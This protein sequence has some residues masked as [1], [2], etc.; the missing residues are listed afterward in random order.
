LGDSEPRGP[1]FLFLVDRF[2]PRPGGYARSLAA[3]LAHFP[4]ESAVV[5]TPRRSGAAV[6]DRA[7][8]CPVRRARTLVGPRGFGLRLWG[9]QVR[10]LVGRREPSLVVA[11]GLGP[12]ATFALSLRE[13]R[14]L[15]F[16][17]RVG[18]AEL[19][20]MRAAIQ[21]G[22]EAGQRAR[23][24]VDEAAA[25]LVP[26]RTAWLEAYKLHTRPHDIL[27]IAPGVDLERF[28]P[29]ATD[30]GLAQ[31]LGIGKNPVVLAVS[32]RDPALDPE[33]ILRAFAAVRAQLRRAVLVAGGFPEGPWHALARKLQVSDG[34]KFI[35]A[36]TVDL[37]ALYRLA[38]V[39][40]L[41]HSDRRGGQGP[42]QGTELPLL[43]AMASGVPVVATR[44]PATEELVPPAEVAQLE[45][46]GAH[47]KLARALLE[48]LRERDSRAEEAGH[49]REWVQEHC[50]AKV[51][52]A[53]LRESLE[54]IVVRRLRREP[55]PAVPSGEAVDPAA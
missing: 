14:D 17:L 6:P 2:P 32:D 25:I 33:T 41:A 13:E 24:L 20:A 16:V 30:N 21:A 37:A 40:L 15:P 36:D 29:G 5:S 7:L 43:E 39:F 44:T 54:V 11:C 50:D 23:R 35:D 1:R 27:T 28:R 8:P 4:S 26:T 22:S 3:E 38:N 47:A 12:E 53:Q 46:P 10:W 19:V 45:E 34:V 9:A 55:P 49:A 18:T 51:S 42:V 52:A 48:A 31:R